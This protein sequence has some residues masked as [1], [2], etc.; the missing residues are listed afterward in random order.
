MFMSLQPLDMK[1][2]M[3]PTENLDGTQLF[4]PSGSREQG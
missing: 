4:F 1:V 2:E 3:A